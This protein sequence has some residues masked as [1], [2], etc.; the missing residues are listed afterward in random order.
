MSEATEEEVMC[1]ACGGAKHL[2]F[3]P[4]HGERPICRPCFMIWYDGMP[5]E[6]DACDPKKVGAESLRLKALGEWPWTGQYAEPD[7]RVASVL[8]DAK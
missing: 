2:R 6:N 8:G 5:N 4:F 3:S 7:N 1:S